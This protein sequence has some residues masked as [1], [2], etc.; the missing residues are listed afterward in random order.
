MDKKGF[1]LLEVLIA[2]LIGSITAAC[3]A[4]YISFL[5]RLHNQM[6][7]R[8]VAGDAIHAMA[9]SIRF[10]LSLFQV[11]FD[12]SNTKEKELL[13]PAKLPLAIAN[14][15]IVQR[16]ECAS[17]TTVIRCQAYVGYIIIPSMIVRNVYEVK[18]LAVSTDA[19]AKWKQNFSYFITVK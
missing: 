12:N 11:S 8:R 5:A 17:K 9:E 4:S 14:N 13:D 10:N 16:S 6:K 19:E 1:T 3:I 2:L 7:L 15:G 18:F